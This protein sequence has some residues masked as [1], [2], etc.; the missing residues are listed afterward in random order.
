VVPDV[1]I[2]SAE[3]LGIGL[4]LDWQFAYADTDAYPVD[5]ASMT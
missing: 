5:S 4:A 3:I 1:T 2:S